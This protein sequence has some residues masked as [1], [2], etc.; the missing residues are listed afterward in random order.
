LRKAA[1]RALT[2][3]TGVVLRAADIEHGSTDGSGARDIHVGYP[4]VVR[5]T[6]YGAVV[7][8]V[9]P[10]GEDDLQA[11]LRKLHWGVGWL[12]AL[13]WRIRS[14]EDKARLERA[15]AALDVL[16]VTQEQ[17]RLRP[18]VIACANELVRRLN[19]DR[20]AIGWKKGNGIRLQTLSH[21]SQVERKA[22]FVDAIENAMDEALDQNASISHPP[23][24]SES[25]RVTV[26]LR[27]LANANGFVAAASVV[28]PARGNAFGVITFMRAKGDAFDSDTMQL[29]KAIAGLVGPL[30]AHK[31]HENRWV[32]GRLADNLGIF[33]HALF[34]KRHPTL[35]IATLCALA[36]AAYAAVATGPFDVSAKA[37]VEG[38]VQRAAVVP[39]D[40]YL[41]EAPARAGDVVRAGQVL[42]VL[43]DKDIQLDRLKW[44]TEKDKALQKMREA[45]ADHDRAGIA[46][47]S[48]EA[49]QADAQ[50]ALVE[51][52][53][54]RTQISAPID[55]FVVS[56]D[57][58]QMLGAPVEKGRVLFEI[59][60]LRS[61]RVILQVDE[62]DIRYVHVD[63]PGTLALTGKPDAR[64]D[65][66]VSNITSIA[67]ADEG[68]NYFRAEA[69]LDKG[70]E[71]LRPGMEGVV[72]L[73]GEKRKLAWI[74]TH[75]LVEWL[76][77]TWWTWKPQ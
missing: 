2:E 51:Q 45:S 30:I 10:P 29:A 77:L 7:V 5:G 53:L 38:S 26:A 60:P 18:A 17:T 62:R 15:A 6:L 12:E 64:F 56:G 48:A 32:A 31:A 24:A 34:G 19:C 14:Q 76:Q 1:E 47:Y 67:T 74:W 54:E 27:A 46:T 66:N 36:A 72:R 23:I 75:S 63:Q 8:H 20:V 9:S 70:D 59:A 39:F 40:G 57:L 49:R 69:T 61:Y 44:Q 58:S 13:F 35:K 22:Q 3:R 28:M 55:G 33:V 52:M 37:V 65:V 50:V 71:Q 41:A 4:I 73:T 43:D 16:A 42:A 21:M 25:R 68:R 11:V